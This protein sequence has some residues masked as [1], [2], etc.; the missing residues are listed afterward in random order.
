MLSTVVSYLMTVA[1]TLAGYKTGA[2][3]DA[4]VSAAH[5]A[6]QDSRVEK[7]C[8]WTPDKDL[9]RWLVIRRLVTREFRDVDQRQRRS[10]SIVMDTEEGSALV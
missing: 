4:L 3:I 2:G 7:I 9:A 8:I 1:R 10:S 6:A 5:L